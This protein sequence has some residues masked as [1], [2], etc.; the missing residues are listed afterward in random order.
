[1]ADGRWQMGDGRCESWRPSGSVAAEVCT[2][3]VRSLCTARG[4]FDKHSLRARPLLYRPCAAPASPL[5]VVLRQSR[6]EIGRQRLQS[7]TQVDHAPLLQPALIGAPLDLWHSLSA[8]P[9]PHGE[10]PRS[11]R[12]FRDE[13]LV[14]G[15]P[16]AD[17]KL[18]LTLS[19][20]PSS[21]TPV[22]SST[23][24]VQSPVTD[25]L[26]VMPWAPPG[27]RASWKPGV[28]SLPWNWPIY[29]RA[30]VALHT[31]ADQCRAVGKSRTPLAAP[32]CEPCLITNGLFA[33]LLPDSR[34]CDSVHSPQQITIPQAPGRRRGDP[35]QFALAQPKSPFLELPL[36]RL[37]TGR[38]ILTSA[39]K[40]G[41]FPW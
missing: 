26:G 25:A 28:V 15:L 10:W 14:S 41:A 9:R 19:L 16:Q 40:A 37:C 1:M 23:P 7:S 12:A 13:S 5:S 33:F 3:L 30:L 20:P 31:N 38:V 8:G 34:G 36:R 18:S 27:S 17:G 6:A 4:G 39:I 21:P 2:T 32:G 11:I 29:P 35:A 22:T 24:P